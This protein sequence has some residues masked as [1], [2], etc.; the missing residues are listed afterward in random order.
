MFDG[1]EKIKISEEETSEY[2]IPFRIPSSGTGT[3]SDQTALQDM[4]ANTGGTF[5]GTPLIN[6]TYYLAPPASA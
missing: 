5:T 4:F 1:C 3:S 6:T 2:S